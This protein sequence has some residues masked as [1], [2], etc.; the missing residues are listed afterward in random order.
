VIFF[1]E[2]IAKNFCFAKIFQ[3]RHPCGGR[4]PFF[5][6]FAIKPL[7]RMFTVTMLLFIAVIPAHASK[8]SLPILKN[9]GSAIKTDSLKEKTAD[10]LKKSGPLSKKS[11][12]PALATTP[13]KSSVK[14]KKTSVSA[15]KNDI[16]PKSQKTVKVKKSG[17]DFGKIFI[18]IVRKVPQA[19]HAPDVMFKNVVQFTKKNLIKISIFLFF[20]IVIVITVLFFRQR[21]EIRRFMTTTRLSV[22]DKEVQRACR[23]IESNFDDVELS[24]DKLCTELVTG[25]AFLTALF[26]RINRAKI[27]FKKDHSA[28]NSAIALKAGFSDIEQFKKTFEKLSGVSVDDYKKALL[29]DQNIL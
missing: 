5:K 21:F 7:Y 26:S 14:N 23:F 27:F 24:V 28:E 1:L 10:T 4:D 19:I 6:G 11:D 8:D 9:T 12:T 18:G 17:N 16:S 29:T 25:K 22:M 2:V 13:Q 20:L 3:L 15:P